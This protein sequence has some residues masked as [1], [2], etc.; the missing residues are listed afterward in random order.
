MLDRSVL[1]WGGLAAVVGSVIAFVFNLLHPRSSAAPGNVEAEL[2]LV[3]GSDIWLFDHYMLAWAIGL[4]VTGLIAIGWSLREGPSASWGRFALAHAIAGGVVGFVTVLVDGMGQKSVA[5]AW[6]ANPGPETLAAATAVSEVSVALFTG[7]AGSLFGF[8][9]IFFGIALLADDGYAKWLGWLPIASGTLGVIVS[10]MQF[11]GGLSNLSANFLFPIA[12][13][14][15]TVWIAIMGWRL[16]KG[17]P[18][19]TGAAPAR[20]TANV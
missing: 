18:A 17:A 9:P 15:F 11:L 16:W 2:E 12:S 14:A 19:G 5:T 6:A 20:S 3:A 7:L 8:A 4:S 1:R 10:S 13:L